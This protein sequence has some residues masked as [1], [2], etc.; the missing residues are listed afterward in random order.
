[1]TEKKQ[2]C[3]KNP[4]DIE[5]PQSIIESFARFLVPEIRKFYESEQGQKEFAEWQERKTEHKTD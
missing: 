4:Y 2:G 5:L 1:M 3:S